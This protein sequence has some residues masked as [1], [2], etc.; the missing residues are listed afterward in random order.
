MSQAD[1]QI[2]RRVYEAAARRDRAAVFELYD[3]D[4]ELDLSRVP[5]GPLIGRTIYH[6]HDGLRA[7]FGDWF[8]AFAGYE[9][10]VD[11]L[12]DAGE[13]VISVLTGRARGRASGVDVEQSFVALWTV[14]NGKVFRLVWYPTR[15]EAIEAA[16]LERDP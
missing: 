6:G 11:E 9:E 8:E 7:L 14:R 10:H 4:V 15:A 3:S 13:H 1:L 5:T 16:G 12:I 2:V